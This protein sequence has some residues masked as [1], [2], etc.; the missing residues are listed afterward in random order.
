MS[1]RLPILLLMVAAAMARGAEGQLLVCGWD[2]VF[3]LNVETG[4]KSF[5]WKAAD[6]PRLPAAYKDKFRTTDDCKA[7]A[8]NRILITAS[9]DGIALVERASGRASFWGLC[10]NVHSA[11]LLPG[12]RIA[13]ACSVR[14]SGG[15]RLA[16]FDGR[17]PEKEL[18]STELYSGH[19]AYWDEGRKLLW[20]LGGRDLRAYALAG[21]ESA[22][23][24]LELQKSYPL[25][26][27][28]GHELSPAA[29]AAL[30]IT[31][32][33]DAWLFDRDKGVF[34]RHPQF[35]GMTDVKSVSLNRA[36]GQV[37]FTVA[38]KPDWWTSRIRF[39]N[40]ERILTREGERL[41]K[42]RWVE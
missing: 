32:E 15:N 26:M 18:Y 33:G 13:A 5:S 21:W 34:N 2:E 14:D 23:P 38:E 36:T 1:I 9:S 16:V 4:A 28:G 17:T 35:G 6:D 11:D 22:T 29:G 31:A 24:S 40:P 20:A 41:Y 8:G 10:A 37:A 19:G 25:P 12:D 39:L 42:V 3:I 30:N 7:V 27:N